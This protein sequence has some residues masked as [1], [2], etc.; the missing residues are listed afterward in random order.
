M[1]KEAMKICIKALIRPKKTDAE[2]IYNILFIDDASEMKKQIIDYF[3]VN[4]ASNHTILKYVTELEVNDIE[5]DKF[6][7][8]YLKIVRKYKPQKTD[9]RMILFLGERE[10]FES[11][12][13][14]MGKCSSK[15]IEFDEKETVIKSNGKTEDG[16][17][18]ELRFNADQIRVMK[19]AI[20]KYHSS[21]PCSENPLAA[22]LL[23]SVKMH[24]TKKYRTMKK[25][26]NECHLKAS[27]IK[28][29]YKAYKQRND[30]VFNNNKHT[31]VDDFKAIVVH[32]S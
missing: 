16:K 8:E 18:E 12:G 5:Y 27:A 17:V 14:A 3:K 22:M 1:S 29:V 24:S 4:F 2:Q 28:R 26:A 7:Y 9:D 31:I 15:K 20:N 30:T 23:P 19:L 32:E 13:L 10:F 25:Y 6:Y 21:E 11:Y